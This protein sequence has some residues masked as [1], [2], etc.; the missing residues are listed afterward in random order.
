ME[1][2]GFGDGGFFIFK[3]DHIMSLHKYENGDLRITQI[4]GGNAHRQ[5]VLAGLENWIKMAT[6]EGLVRQFF[7]E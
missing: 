5:A 2:R 6:I 4:I 3:G 7:R 1:L